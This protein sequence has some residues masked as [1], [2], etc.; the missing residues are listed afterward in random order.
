MTDSQARV[1][2]AV[3]IVFGVTP[4]SLAT[5]QDALRLMIQMESN[6]RADCIRELIAERIYSDSQKEEIREI[7]FRDYDGPVEPEPIQ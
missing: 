3:G 5:L 6:F 1:R 4:I 2:E 7:L